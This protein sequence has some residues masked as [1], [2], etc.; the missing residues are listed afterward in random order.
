MPISQYSDHQDGVMLCRRGLLRTTVFVLLAAPAAA[1]AQDAVVYDMAVR[2]DP[3]CPCC[4]LWVALMEETGR[5]RPT[6]TDE[7]DMAGLKQSLGVPADLASCHT[8]VVEGLVFEGHVPA[9]DMFRLL[10]ERPAGVLGLAVPGMPLGSP[11]ME[12][13]DGRTQPYTVFAFKA[14]GTR[15][16][17][18]SYGA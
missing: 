17:F 3:G 5:F 14:D 12:T 4:H 6:M 2:R 18:A 13:P 7:A 15:D 1:C 10:A 16:A 8:A 11:G 9:A